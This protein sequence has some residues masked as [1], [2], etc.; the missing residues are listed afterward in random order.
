MLQQPRDA[1]NLLL[2]E[3]DALIITAVQ[4]DGVWQDVS[5]YGDLVWRLIPTT[6]N[7]TPSSRRLDFNNVPPQFREALKAI[8]YRYQRQGRK[9][10]PRPSA[11]SVVKQ[12]NCSLPFLRYLNSLNIRRLGEVT[13]LAC[14]TYATACE[15]A[16][17]KSGKALAKGSLWQR[18]QAVEALYELSQG[19]DDPMPQH[20][21]PESSSRTLAG[22][23]HHAGLASHHAKTP[24]IPDAIFSTLFQAAWAA[25]ERADLLLDLRDELDRIA[26]EKA[27]K[28][29][30][31][32]LDA[33]NAFL[34]ARKWNGRLATFSPALLELRT[35]CYIV[36]ASLSGCRNHEMAYLQTAAY[37]S[38]TD[39]DGQ[40]YWWMKSKSTKTGEGHTEWMIPEAAVQALKV[41]DRWAKPYQERVRAELA[42]RR[43]A[44]AADPAIAEALK[45]IDAIFLG[46]ERSQG[47]QVRTLP[48]CAW[49]VS[50]KKFAK[51]HHIAWSL[52]THQF[53]RT[54][55]VYA[56]RSTFGD[57]RY[58]KQHFKHWSMDMSLLYAINELQEMALFNEITDELDDIQQGVMATWLDPE[59]PLSGGAGQ[60]MKRFRDDNPIPMYTDRV[61]M[62]KTL[63]EHVH[64]R[65]NGHAWCTADSGSDCIG[66]GGF[67]RTRCSDCAHAVIAPIHVRMYQG[68]YNH[69]QGLLTL[70]DIGEAGLTR[71]RRDV[72]R[73]AN[74]M[75][76]LGHDPQ[77]K[78]RHDQHQPPHG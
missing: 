47:N 37:Y 2:N 76:D 39:R 74:V 36:V 11:G 33:K 27:G 78:E 25:V 20:P 8:L 16:L 4:V 42:A 5:R 67:D 60:G 28:D 1:A 50:L 63:A 15:K 40:R 3:R 55:A 44:P 52:S 26:Q 69:L 62:A 31:T 72:E 70:E 10:M 13:P 18:Y 65:S 71:V 48:N 43:V 12:F 17:K 61:T 46:V 21:W 49:N 38:T 51:R 75:R 22:L 41:M 57:L 54:F 32:V 73:C 64:I 7:T 24:R 66:N 14:S 30:S 35:A 68:L 58:L 29:P 34:D 77:C 56:A 9:G 53:R 6:T 59:V 45:H 23:T 19:S